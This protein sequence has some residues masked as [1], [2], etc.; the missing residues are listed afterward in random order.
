MSSAARPA[1]HEPRLSPRPPQ[2]AGSA[3]IDCSS[4]PL[5]RQV[6]LRRPT[7]ALPAPPRP[8]A[9][10]H[11]RLL[12]KPPDLD[13]HGVDLPREPNGPASPRHPPDPH[14]KTSKAFPILRVPARRAGF[15]RRPGFLNRDWR[16]GFA[17]SNPLWLDGSVRSYTRSPYQIS[18]P[19]R[20]ANDSGPAINQRDT[21]PRMRQGEYARSLR[22]DVITIGPGTVN[23]PIRVRARTKAASSAA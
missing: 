15:R 3:A 5:A 2:W 1:K 8:L 14:K 17:D 19:S 20:R 18:R 16:S 13:Q 6:G 12:D 4:K 22:P 10:E 23:R 7:T 11:R 9:R 21:T